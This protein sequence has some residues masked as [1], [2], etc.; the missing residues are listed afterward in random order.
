MIDDW[1]AQIWAHYLKK[2][3]LHPELAVRSGGQVAWALRKE[4]P[5]LRA[6]CDAFIAGGL[7]Q[8]L[9]KV[10]MKVKGGAAQ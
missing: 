3:K 6:E 5:Q 9:D 10:L 7:K 8:G 2:V 4:S 1:I